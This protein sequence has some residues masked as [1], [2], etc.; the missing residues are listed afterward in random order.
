MG[1][2]QRI[3]SIRDPDPRPGAG[4]PG[5]V[6]SGRRSGCSAGQRPSTGDTTIGPVLDHSAHSRTAGG[7]DQG[8][9]TEIGRLFVSQSGAHIHR[10]LEPDSTRGLSTAGWRRSD[11]IRPPPARIRCAGPSRRSSIVGPRT[12]R[13]C[14][15]CSATPSLRA[16]YDTSESRSTTPWRWQSKL[17]CNAAAPVVTAGTTVA[18]RPSVTLPDGK[19]LDVA[20]GRN[21]TLGHR[22]P[23]ADADWLAASDGQEPLGSI[24]RLAAFD[25]WAVT[26][27]I[28]GGQWRPCENVARPAYRCGRGSLVR[29]AAMSPGS[30]QRPLDAD[31]EG[32][33]SSRRALGSMPFGQ[34]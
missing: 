27:L 17:R 22:L 11:S 29:R 6:A 10:S 25:L 2:R 18:G 1:R 8:C 30:A 14:S 24:P 28:E 3:F 20:T 21:R 19:E 33:R 31:S 23:L 12:L 16:L 13:R 15:Y 26:G 7:V 5:A 9:G 34:A 32:V 4:K